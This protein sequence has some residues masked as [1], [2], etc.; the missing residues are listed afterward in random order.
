MRRLS[1]S[2]FWRRIRLSA[3]A[4]L[5]LILLLGACDR[6]AHGPLKHEAYIWQRQWTPALAAAMAEQE[7]SFS[8]WRVLLLQVVG[9]RL[10]EA[11]PDA[12]ALQSS[13]KPLIWVIR[14]EGARQPLPAAA[15]VAQLQPILERWQQRGLQVSAIEI[16]HDCA[17]AALADYGLWLSQLRALLPNAMGL[18]ITALPTWLGSP[19]LASVLSQVDSSVL[20]VH[21]VDQPDRGLFNA[22]QALQWIGEYAGLA[23]TFFVALPAYGVRVA[24]NAEG[25][26]AAV[27]AEGDIDRSGA[28]GRELRADPR[29]IAGF[30]QK[31][32]AE[33]PEGLQGLA[34]FRLPLRDDRR[35]W[36]A[37]T[38]RAVIG[39]EALRL[40]F[41]VRAQSTSGASY[42]LRLFNVGNL[43]SSAPNVNLPPDC[44][45]ADALGPFRL[46]DD[47]RSLQFQA[48]TEVWIRSGESILLGWARCNTPLDQSWDVK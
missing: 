38:L 47:G 1:G 45:L 35:S 19:D 31:L 7:G 33:R 5:S 41:Q 9:E 12:L 6:H 28:A 14:I 48:D 20:Q 22:D 21:A 10:I 29:E 44:R 18:S 37:R 8:G 13:T 16:D 30:L 42:D 40:Q 24:T 43:D 26:V 17:T 2:A 23:R 46:R 36:S 4:L 15:L 3:G 39:A 34:W 32:D 27:D 25:A 11:E